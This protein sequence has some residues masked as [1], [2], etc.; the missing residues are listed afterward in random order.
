MLGWIDERL[1]ELWK[2]RGPSPGL[3]SA[4]TAF[5]IEHGNF[6]ALELSAA[7][8]ENEDPFP[9]LD[10][11]MDGDVRLSERAEG[12]ISRTR[13]DQW[14][15]IREKRPQRR[16]FLELLARFELSRDQAE[17]L[18]IVEER[19]LR[20]PELRDE[21]IL[22]N[23]YLVYEHDRISKDP[24]SV[25]TA[26]RGVFPSAV[27]RDAHPLPQ[28]S[29]V[30]DPTDPRRVRALTIQALETAAAEGHTLQP[31]ASVVRAIRGFP[32]DRPPLWTVTSW[33]CS[34]RALRHVCS[35]PRW[36]P[37]NP[38]T[39]STASMKPHAL[40]ALSS[41]SA[42]PEFATK[43]MHRGASF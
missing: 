33:T 40:S 24:I 15:A 5:G 26:D 1:G 22:A 11:V 28:P 37:M 8:E 39:S 2:L 21:D 14:I 20:W 42:C 12:Y 4:L 17:R 38:R 13:R 3:G 35:S 18:Y 7:L 16:Q 23:P 30:D 31:R 29:C 19:E 36:V 27:V 6:L 10:R 9:L 43:L 25:W 41:R 32:L 34:K